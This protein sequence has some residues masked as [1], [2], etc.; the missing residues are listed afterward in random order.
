LCCVVVSEEREAVVVQ[1]ACEVGDIAAED[2]VAVLYGL[3]SWR[4]AR[5]APV[6]YER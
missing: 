3:V 2:E 6:R 4:V 1:A 5:L